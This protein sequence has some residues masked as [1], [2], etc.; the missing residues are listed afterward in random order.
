MISNSG[1]DGSGASFDD[2]VT[3]FNMRINLAF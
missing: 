3:V 2:N 1:F